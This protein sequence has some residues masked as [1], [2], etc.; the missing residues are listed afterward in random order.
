MHLGSEDGR[1]TTDR[2][3][4]DSPLEVQGFAMYGTAS[5]AALDEYMEVSVDD[6]FP[7]L[8]FPVGHFRNVTLRD[9]VDD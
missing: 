3:A 5:R 7:D 6:V 4:L 1:L 9:D 8:E 2:D